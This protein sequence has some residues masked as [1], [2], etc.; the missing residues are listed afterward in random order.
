MELSS[1]N[2]NKILIFSQ[3]EAFLIFSLKKVFLIFQ[4]MEPCTFQLKI[5][6]QKS[7]PRESFL[8]FRKWKP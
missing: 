4:E 7:P 3:K 8:Y 1:A 2:I 5:E 6:K